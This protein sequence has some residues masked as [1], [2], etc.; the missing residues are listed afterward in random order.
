MHLSA[1]VLLAGLSATPQLLVFGG[2]YGPD[3]NQASIEADVLRLEQVL[4]PAHPT[5][6]FAGGSSSIRSVQ[7]AT[8]SDEVT[9]RLGLLYGHT[10]GLAVDYRRPR[11][12]PD[13]AARR[14][15]VI[16]ALV[17]LRGRPGGGIAFGVGHGGPPTAGS[18]ATWA[19]WDAELT[20]AELVERLER[21]PAKGP[22]ALVLGQ[23]HSGA[24][25]SV[26]YEG[27]NR[28]A[29]LARPA[30]CALA[31]VPRDLEAAGCS[32]DADDPDALAFI[33]AIARALSGAGDLDESGLVDLDEAFAYAQIHDRTIDVPVRSSDVWLETHAPEIDLEG[34]SRAELFAMASPLDR[35][36]LAALVP[37]GEPKAVMARLDTLIAAAEDSTREIDALQVALDD[38][39]ALAFAAALETFPELSNPLHP[40]SRALLSGAAPELMSWWEKHPE[41]LAR[42]EAA[43][44]Q[45]TAAL[46]HRWGLER[47]LA[48]LDRWSR[49]AWSV[50]ATRAL[51]P[52]QRRDFERLRA[53]ERMSP[54]LKP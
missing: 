37:E 32:P 22:L 17:K 23:C 35:T 13:G 44:A 50:V 9:R 28:E 19:L 3:S 6:L 54:G 49:R 40:R 26:M 34:T 20:P 29:A 39:R 2:G 7:T 36:V 8:G 48:R 21:A 53:C 38:A 11:L 33:A 43:S 1:A 24:F 12:A 31:A 18:A 51:A 10:A 52:N 45:V 30:R 5:V 25:A 14:Q 27:A 42:L 41:P 15:T 47:A 16:E 4:A 46:D